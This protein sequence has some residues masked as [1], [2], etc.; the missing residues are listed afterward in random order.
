MFITT[1][2]A[3]AALAAPGEDVKCAVM[4]SPTN[5]KS[6]AVEFSGARFPMCCGGCPEAFSKDPGKFIKDAAKSNE[7][8]GVFLFCPVSGER[9]DMDKVKETSNYKG[10]KY[11]FCCA[12]CKGAFEK[13]PA[14]FAKSPEKESLTCAVSGEKIA[15]YSEAA[16]FV[17]YNG[18]RYYICCANCGPALK[19]D[20][21]GVIAKN[22][23]KAVAPSAVPSP[24]KKVD[25]NAVKTCTDCKGK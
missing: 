14:K 5:E 17:D 3:F 19:K 15:S 21:A 10:I 2:I 11:G 9:I 24:T 13:D 4:H 16:G 23:I 8:I 7:T 25:V 12:D 22:K 6:K 1:L 18:A 20:P